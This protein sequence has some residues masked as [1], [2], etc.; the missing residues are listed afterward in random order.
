MPYEV[1]YALREVHEGV[2]GSH[3]GARTLAYKV[4]RQR[5]GIPN[6]IIAD[7]GLQFN[8][9]S[10]KDFC[11]NYGIKLVFTSVYHPKA[12]GMVESV[13]KAIL[14]GINPSLRVSHFDLAQNEQL[15]R[16]N[17]DFLDEVREQ[18]RL[19]M[20]AYKQ[21][22]ASFYNKRV[23]PRSFRIGDLVLRKARFLGFE[24]HFSKLAPNWE[25]PYPVIKIPHLGT[26]I[27]QDS[28]GK[29]VPK[30]WNVNNL[31]KFYP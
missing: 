4:L 10:F 8:C 14:E 3:V 11:S 28:E 26:Y 16:E 1:E 18:C 24:T 7:N 17:L 19:R 5:Y 31:K 25:G 6:Q 22:V 12:N 29:R 20:L 9:N 13:N 21:K 30:V 15:L 27:L 23:R 2:C